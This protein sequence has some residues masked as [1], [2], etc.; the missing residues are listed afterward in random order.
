MVP[1]YSWFWLW[2]SINAPNSKS[3]TWDLTHGAGDL[4]SWRQCE[5]C[6]F[7]EPSGQNQPYHT[8]LLS[9][10]WYLSRSFFLKDLF[11][12]TLPFEYLKNTGSWMPASPFVVKVEIC[13]SFVSEKGIFLPEN[14]FVFLSFQ[15]TFFFSKRQC[16]IQWTNESR[17]SQDWEMVWTIFQFSLLYTLRQGKNIHR[18]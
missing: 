7:I 8:T 5:F 4:D 3:Q 14:D 11:N 13:I 10:I 15:T 1:C 9:K 16:F 12:C 18:G 2:G 6:A 17:L